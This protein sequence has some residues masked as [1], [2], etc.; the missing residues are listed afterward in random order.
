MAISRIYQQARETP[1]KT[2][3]VHNGRPLSYAEFAQRIEAARQYL[4]RRELPP[5][6]AVLCFESLLDV[7]IVGFALR[8]L[9]VTTIASSSSD[10]LIGFCR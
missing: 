9:G 3:V 2:A 7:W 8:S 10:C 4:S 5:G 6:V 1:G